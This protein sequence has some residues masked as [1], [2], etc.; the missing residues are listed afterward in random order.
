[1][2][3]KSLWFYIS[4]IG[5]A[6]TTPL[7]FDQ[8]PIKLSQESQGQAWGRIKRAPIL[9]IWYAPPRHWSE[10]GNSQDLM[11]STKAKELKIKELQKLGLTIRKLQIWEILLMRKHSDQLA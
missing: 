8:E 5:F 2:L 3:C 6:T 1:M 7:I 10:L 9:R 11:D 4:L